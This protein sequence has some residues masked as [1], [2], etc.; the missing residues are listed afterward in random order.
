MHLVYSGGM[1]NKPTTTPLALAALHATE[2][3]RATKDRNAAIRAASEE[4]ASLRTIATE[5]GLSFSAIGKI[6]RKTNQES[7]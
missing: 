6:L 1:A 3:N 7:T 5:T 2:A 4:G